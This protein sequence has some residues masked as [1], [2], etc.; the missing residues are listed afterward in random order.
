MLINLLFLSPTMLQPIIFHLIGC[1]DVASD[2]FRGFNFLPSF[3]SFVFFFFFFE[4]IPGDGFLQA[5]HMI[6]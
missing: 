3:V 6:L 5:F 1:V 2:N 4:V